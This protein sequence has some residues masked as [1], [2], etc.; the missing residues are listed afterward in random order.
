MTLATEL[1]GLPLPTRLSP[2]AWF[3]GRDYVARELA[4]SVGRLRK[5]L[6]I[7]EQGGGCLAFTS[8]QVD[9]GF[10]A[11]RHNGRSIPVER[12]GVR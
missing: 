10:A 7:A 2:E 8:R 6:G 4:R 11:I 1:N 5:V 9:A 3:V 12:R